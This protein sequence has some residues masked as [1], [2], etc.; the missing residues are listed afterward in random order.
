MLFTYLGTHYRSPE[1]GPWARMGPQGQSSCEDSHC[2]LRALPWTLIQHKYV[3]VGSSTSHW[4]DLWTLI[5]LWNC[6]W[7]HD[8]FCR[9]V[10]NDFP[11]YVVSFL[12]FRI[13][14]PA[15]GRC[16]GDWE[17]VAICDH[18][19]QISGHLLGIARRLPALW[20]LVELLKLVGSAGSQHFQVPWAPLQR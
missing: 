12:T 20:L 3:I 1:R 10:V 14:Y 13:M 15:G 4:A 19:Y 18:G 9:D 2:Y 5:K 17:R 6:V 8:V 16:L 11:S 7:A